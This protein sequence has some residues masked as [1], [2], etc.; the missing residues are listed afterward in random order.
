VEKVK[1]RRI[2]IPSKWFKNCFGCF[3]TFQ[4]ARKRIGKINKVRSKKIIDKPSAPR[5][6]VRLYSGMGWY[7]ET[8]WN[9]KSALLNAAEA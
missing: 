9:A 6:K 4:A 1:T 7:R 3:A 2:S 8:N 5:V